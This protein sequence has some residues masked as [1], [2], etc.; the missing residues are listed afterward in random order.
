M[1][2]EQP[3]ANKVAHHLSI[4]L[5]QLG[6]VITSLPLAIAVNVTMAGIMELVG[7]LIKHWTGQS[8]STIHGNDWIT[9]PAHAIELS[10]VIV[11]WI[12]VFEMLGIDSGIDIKSLGLHKSEDA[13]DDDNAQCN[14]QLLDQ[15]AMA[16]GSSDAVDEQKQSDNDI[17]N[18]RKPEE[19]AQTMKKQE[20][21]VAEP[22][23]NALEKKEKFSS[24]K[25]F[26]KTLAFWSGVLAVILWWVCLVMVF[27][28]EAEYGVK[29][30]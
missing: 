13:I 14:R 22:G 2:F 12:A 26:G 21:Q 27:D 20:G 19:K 3:W 8:L 10:S 4:G 9:M 16:I 25:L 18:G 17:H 15:L 5:T 6:N 28:L 11:I 30:L 7:I 29:H 1:P 24:R 23:A